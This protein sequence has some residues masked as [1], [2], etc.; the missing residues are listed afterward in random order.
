MHGGEGEE[1][2]SCQWYS[3]KQGNLL[4]G[5]LTPVIDM[6]ECLRDGGRLKKIVPVGGFTSQNGHRMRSKG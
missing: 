3:Q 2:P 6:R 5:P 4:Y 1:F